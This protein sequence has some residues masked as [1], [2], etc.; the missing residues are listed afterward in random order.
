MT[1]FPMSKYGLNGAYHILFDGST[2]PPDKW[3]S[4][5]ESCGPITS[6]LCMLRSGEKLRNSIQFLYN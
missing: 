6:S 2:F 5:V 3:S 1:A 4:M